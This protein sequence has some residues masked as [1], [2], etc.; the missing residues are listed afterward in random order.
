[1][2]LEGFDLLG[3]LSNRQYN[4]NEQGRTETYTNVVSQYALLKLTY[5]F[6]KLPKGKKEPDSFLFF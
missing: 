2:S 1:M 6:R 5:Q 3:Q 4:I